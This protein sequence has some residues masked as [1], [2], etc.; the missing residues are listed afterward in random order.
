MRQTLVPKVTI[1]SFQPTA[2]IV[3]DVSNILTNEKQQLPY[4]KIFCLKTI[5]IDLRKTGSTQNDMNEK[6]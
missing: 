5:N 1:T 3:I 4:L 6:F 2:K